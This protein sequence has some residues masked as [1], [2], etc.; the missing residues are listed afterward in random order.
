MND[1]VALPSWFYQ[2]N[3][4]NAER[5]NGDRFSDCRVQIAG[6]SGHCLLSWRAGG[7]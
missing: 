5:V 4:A 6:V 2:L 7:L 1:G 3:P